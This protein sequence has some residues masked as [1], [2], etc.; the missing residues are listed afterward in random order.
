MSV[1][2]KPATWKTSDGAEFDNE[3]DATRHEAVVEAIRNYED[4]AKQLGIVLAER[5]KTADGYPFDFSHWQYWAVFPY[6]GCGPIMRRV[7][8]SRWD[9]I[10]IGDNYDNDVQIAEQIGDRP[11]EQ[12]MYHYIKDLYVTEKAAKKALAEAIKKHIATKREEIKR[13]ED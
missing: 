12:Y 11:R 3:A 9:H 5:T 4:A 2:Q 13:L 6:H 1:S 7:N 10:S 8:V